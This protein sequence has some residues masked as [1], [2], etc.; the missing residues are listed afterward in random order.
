MTAVSSEHLRHRS[1]IAIV[2]ALEQLIEDV[3]TVV[4]IEF[5]CEYIVCSRTINQTFGG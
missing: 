4:L 5:D 3:R 2:P 1:M